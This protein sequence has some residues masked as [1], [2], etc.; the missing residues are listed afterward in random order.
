MKDAKKKRNA[1]VAG[2]VN[3]AFLIIATTLF[4]YAV[5]RYIHAGRDE[6]IRNT[7]AAA[8]GGVLLAYLSTVSVLRG[9]VNEINAS[10]MGRFVFLYVSC[11]LSCAA[12]RMVPFTGWPFMAFY[13]AL[14]LVSNETIGLFSGTVL[15]VLASFLSSA[16]RTAVLLYLLLG[17]FVIILH[18]GSG[19]RAVIRSVVLPAVL[20]QILLDLACVLLFVHTETTPA[21]FTAPLVNAGVT[22]VLILFILYVYHTVFAIGDTERYPDINDPE[23][24]L[25]AAIRSKS[26]E[27]YFRAIHTA[28]LAERVAKAL[29]ANA[30][31]VKTCAYYNRIGCL[32]D[33]ESI[34]SEVEHYYR[35]FDFPKEACDLLREYISMGSRGPV[36]P[37]ATI[38][39]LCDTLVMSLQYVFHKNKDAK[40]SY[41]DM[42]DRLFAHKT[43]AGELGASRM[44]MADYKTM[45]DLLKQE[46]LYYDFLR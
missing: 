45:R 4:A 9:R 24:S 37:E 7:V 3:G 14:Y 6:I 33:T 17:A 8:S 18:Q 36:S 40:V 10:H 44:T 22:A 27:E 15:L 38:V 25:M 43:E 32:D 5:S 29:K 11:L 39:W 20:L 46:K 13:L 41:D 21:M 19:D 28:Y 30:R 26:E 34:W 16:D 31:A 42:I 12:L 23:F 35:E 1:A 2:S